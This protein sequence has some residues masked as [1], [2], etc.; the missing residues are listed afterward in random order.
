M[1]LLGD[2]VCLFNEARVTVDLRPCLWK[3]WQVL[4]AD[5]PQTGPLN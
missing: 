2:Q 5:F 3:W 4:V 1:L